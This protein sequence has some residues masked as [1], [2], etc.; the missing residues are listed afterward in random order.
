M[1]D[2]EQAETTAIYYNRKVVVSEVH[3][4]GEFLMAKVWIPY[5]VPFPNGEYEA[6][7]LAENLSD[8]R[9]GECDSGV[10]D[11]YECDNCKIKRILGDDEPERIPF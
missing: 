6:I 9:Y 5:E 11:S 3:W 2:L 7:V 8:I 10:F 1:M 4:E